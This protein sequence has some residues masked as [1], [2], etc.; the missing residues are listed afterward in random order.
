M[1][2]IDKYPKKVPTISDFFL[3]SKFKSQNQTVN[4]E[5][6]EVI[7]LINELNGVSTTIY[8]FSEFID[9][10]TTEGYF[11]TNQGVTDFSQITEIVINA[12]DYNS[13][14]LTEAFDNILD[15]KNDILISLRDSNIKGVYYYFRVESF[16]KSTEYYTLNVEMVE[17]ISNGELTEGISLNLSF[18]VNQKVPTPQHDEFIATANQTEHV[19]NKSASILWVDINRVPQYKSRYT[20]DNNKT[21]TFNP[22]LDQGDVVSIHAT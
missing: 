15:N 21:I 6:S 13:V 7:S 14:D 19:L 16:V 18:T 9:A 12:N 11:N 8:K 5:F 4:F 20:F 10:Q 22:P 1:S 2:K 3:G 17:T